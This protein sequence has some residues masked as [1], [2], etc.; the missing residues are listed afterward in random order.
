MMTPIRD[1][2]EASGIT[3]NYF[4]AHIVNTFDGKSM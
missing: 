3:Q 4:G 1:I 2:C